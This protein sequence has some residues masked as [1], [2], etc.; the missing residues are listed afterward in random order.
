MILGSYYGP[1]LPLRI[2]AQLFE[3]LEEIFLLVV[4][5]DRLTPLD[6]GVVTLLG[7]KDGRD[8]ASPKAVELGDEFGLLLKRPLRRVGLGLI[9]IPPCELKTDYFLGRLARLA[10]E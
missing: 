7:V 10:L 9:Y 3:A 5:Q 1:R 6:Y 2:Y 8:G 4:V